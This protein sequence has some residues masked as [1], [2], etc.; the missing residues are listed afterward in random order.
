MFLSLPPRKSHV[1]RPNILNYGGR[2][3]LQFRNGFAPRSPLQKSR[4]PPSNPE[5]HIQQDKTGSKLWSDYDIRRTAEVSDTSHSLAQLMIRDY[6]QYKITICLVCTVADAPY[7]D[8]VDEAL[9]RALVVLASLT[10][11]PLETTWST[12]AAMLG[13]PSESTTTAFATRHE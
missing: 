13:Y 10:V 9:A 4:P 1:L 6:C 8:A 5:N 3:D 7:L 12:L 2:S 11:S